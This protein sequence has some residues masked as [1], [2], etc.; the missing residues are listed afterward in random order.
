[1]TAIKFRKRLL[2]RMAVQYLADAMSGLQF[3]RRA[4]GRSAPARAGTAALRV[5][6]VCYGSKIPTDHMVRIGSVGRWRRVYVIQ[7]GNV[8]SAYVMVKGARFFLR[9]YEL[10]FLSD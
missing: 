1:M 6:G 10:P 8:G 3:C 7:Y 9:D 5:G 2:D 4:P